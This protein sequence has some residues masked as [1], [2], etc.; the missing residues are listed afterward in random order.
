M[1]SGV[2]TI[3]YVVYYA[4][5]KVKTQPHVYLIMLSQHN[6]YQT[7]TSFIITFVFV[8]NSNSI[9]NR[10]MPTQYVSNNVQLYVLIPQ[11]IPRIR[12]KLNP[13]PHFSLFFIIKNFV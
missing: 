10:C 11:D 2:V 6:D 13:H 4:I 12:K 1:Y 5:H 8:T 7:Q 9:N 3:V